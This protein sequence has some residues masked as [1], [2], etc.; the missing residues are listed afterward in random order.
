MFPSEYPMNV[1]AAMV[2]FFVCPATFEVPM[3]MHWTHAE[4]KKLMR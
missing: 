2:A 1:P 4:E 3:A